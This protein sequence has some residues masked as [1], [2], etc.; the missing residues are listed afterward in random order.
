VIHVLALYSILIFLSENPQ[1]ISITEI[2]IQGMGNIAQLVICLMYVHM[3]LHT[4]YYN[5]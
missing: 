4:I 3:H 1:E 5:K 2:V